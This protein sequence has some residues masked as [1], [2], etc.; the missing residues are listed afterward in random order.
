MIGY[1]KRFFGSKLGWTAVL[2]HF[3]AVVYSFWG[4]VS[5][6]GECGPFAT[7]AGWVYIAGTGLHWVYESVLMKLLL[8]LDLT[9]LGVAEFV[10]NI[11][12][13]ASWCFMPRTWTLAILGLFFASLQWYVIGMLLQRSFFVPRKTIG[14]E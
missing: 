13:M 1:L 3:I 8:I 4:F 12:G 11:F 10:G 9:A 5:I 2:V 6:D 14:T 7:G